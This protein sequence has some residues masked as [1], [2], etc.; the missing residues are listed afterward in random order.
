MK[1]TKELILYKNFE[2]GK[3]FYNLTW[4]MENYQNEFYNTEDIRALYYECVNQLMEL[5]VS[6]GFEGNLWHCFLAFLI[7][8][9]ENAYSTA[10]EM[11]GRTDGSINEVARHDFAIFKDLFDF[12]GQAMLE[13]LGAQ[14]MGFLFDYRGISGGGKVFNQ[15][16]RDRICELAVHLKNAKDT[17]EFQE[18][19]SEF[20]ADFG[21]GRLGLHKAFRIQH[22]EKEEV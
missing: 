6:H 4:I 18:I 10:C 13:A 16:I 8:N 7:V 2:N 17:E 20:Y 21:V 19:V 11:K 12:D 15:R 3:L 22:R 1:S 9:N 5:S 14:D